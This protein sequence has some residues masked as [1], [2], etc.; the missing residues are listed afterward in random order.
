[1]SRNPLLLLTLLLITAC[2]SKQDKMLA[3]IERYNKTLDM[4][5]SGHLTVEQEAFLMDSVP[6]SVSRKWHDFAL[7]FP[8]H[9]AAEK[10]LYL[11]T[12]KAEQSGRFLD[13]AKWCEDYLKLYPKSPLKFK[14]LV[15]AASNWEKARVWEKAIEYNQRI[16]NEYPKDPVAA[17]AAIVVRMLKLGITD[18]EKQ[19]EYILAE[20]DS[21]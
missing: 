13:C 20:R 12:L 14:A 17:H 6:D 1:M 4:T 16:V 5:A 3:P 2:M 8:Q 18:E 19:L 10:M 21:I 11:A 7:A 9:P 15:A